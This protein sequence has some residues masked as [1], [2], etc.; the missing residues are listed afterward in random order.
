MRR[1]L[2]AFSALAAATTLCL[3]IPA[4][5][6]LSGPTS[7]YSSAPVEASEAEYWRMLDQAGSCLANQK[8]AE[9]E[10]FVDAVIDSQA[11]SAAFGVLF[12][13]GRN[14]RNNCMGSFVSATTI[15]AHVRA[16]VAE[17]LF[18][19]LDD[20]VIAQF[21]A[22]PP[23][24]PATVNT[25]HDFARCYVIA[26]P[27]NAIELLRRTDVSTR[28]ELEFIQEIAADFG[29]CM[30][31]GREVSLRATSVRMAIAEAAWRAATGR[32]APTIQGRN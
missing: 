25:L 8:T 2:S 15:R 23:A 26:Q 28:G 9:S 31:E 18:E 3:A 6:Q 11:E 10:A 30:P 27:I 12:N 7:G 1:A 19:R 13:R 22:N 20:D 14:R 21:V 29:P 4:Q 17:G 16:L 5:A 32:P 24:P